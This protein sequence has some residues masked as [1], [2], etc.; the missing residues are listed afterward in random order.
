VEHYGDHISLH[1]KGNTISNI[2][3][4]PYVPRF[5]ELRTATTS[6]RGKYTVI[7]ITLLGLPSDATD[8]R[9]RSSSNS[10]RSIGTVKTSTGIQNA[11]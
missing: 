1:W 11:T 6:T 10:S 5:L 3:R 2:S 7:T 4:A 9:Q 8:A